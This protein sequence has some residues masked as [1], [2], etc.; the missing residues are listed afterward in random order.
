MPPRVDLQLVPRA[1]LS[2][3]EPHSLA[4]LGDL[5]RQKLDE[6][7]LPRQL[8]RTPSRGYGADRP[9][10]ACGLTILP[11]QVQYELESHG[12]ARNRGSTYRLHL[13]C[14][15]GWEVECRQQGWRGWRRD[16]GA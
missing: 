9:C 16:G 12:G 3:S 14:Y 8:S 2:G 13:G 1:T 10:S 11:T 15:A 7:L 5:I 6:G 4:D